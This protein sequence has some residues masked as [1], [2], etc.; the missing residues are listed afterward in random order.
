MDDTDNVSGDRANFTDRTRSSGRANPS[1][2][3]A[4]ATNDR[5]NA[6]DE[7]ANALN[8]DA[9]VSRRR[10]LSVALGAPMM[11][12]AGWTFCAR[13]V[14]EAATATGA[15]ANGADGAH[16]TQSA[17]GARETVGSASDGT[18][19]AR[20]DGAQEEVA[21]AADGT[22]ADA[23]A[24]AGTPATV[25]VIEFNQAGVKQ[26]PVKVA[27]VVKSDAEWRKLLSPEQYQVTRHAGTEAP[28]HNQYDEWTAVGIYRCICCRNA[29]FS[30]KTKFDSHTG[31]PSFWAPIAAENIRTKVD[32][33]FD[34]DRTEVLCRECD[35]HLGHVF[36]DGPAPTGLRYCMNSA[37]MIFVPTPTAKN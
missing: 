15:Q 10:F 31:W 6:R 11:L 37:A 32:T 36:D 12:A 27:K 1:S 3:R 23:G 24:S 2:N 35:A 34:M 8:A 18:Q 5:I 30:S 33:S 21:A 19:G 22:A 14:A 17:T 29:L 9:N 26:G 7:R 25:T 20:S 28:F 4:S 13:A 16:G